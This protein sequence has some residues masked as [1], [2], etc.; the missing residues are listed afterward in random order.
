MI[1]AK[2]YIE[3]GFSAEDA[4]KLDAIINPIFQKR[5]KVVIDFDGITI[6]TTLFFNTALG[7][8]VMEIGPDEYG[9]LFEL[10]NLSDVGEVTY[11]HSLDNAKNYFALSAEQ[12]KKQDEILSDPE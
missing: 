5:E 4:E 8:Y 6:F 1:L 10:K 3:T 11:Q 12:R 9:K 7:K 2:K